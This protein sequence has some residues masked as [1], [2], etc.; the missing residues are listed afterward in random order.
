[1]R[2]TLYVLLPLAVVWTLAL[3]SQGVIQTFGKPISYQTLEARTLGSVGE[4]GEAVTQ[5]VPRG[6]VASQVAIKSLG[7][8]GGGYFN[9]NAATP[10]ENPTPIANLLHMLALLLIPA[11]LTATFGGWSGRGVRGGSCTGP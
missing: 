4:D 10:F 9:T 5:T 1:M 2:S 11:A 8:V 7:S 6:A 3:G